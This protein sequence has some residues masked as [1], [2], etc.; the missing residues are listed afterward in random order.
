VDVIEELTGLLRR[1]LG[2]VTALQ[3]RLRALELLVAADEQRFLGLALD[4]IEAAEDH[5]ASL[6]L[7]RCLAFSTA[8]IPLDLPAEELVSAVGDPD[9]AARLRAAIRD[10]RRGMLLLDD[11]RRRADAVIRGRLGRAEARLAAAVSETSGAAAS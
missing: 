11:A 3:G 10:L 8:G 4:E 2:A 7:T 1:Q 9:D 6:E 5:L